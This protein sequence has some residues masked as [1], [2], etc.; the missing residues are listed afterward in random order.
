[1]VERD[2]QLGDLVL[3]NYVGGSRR[4]SRPVLLE[5]AVD[6]GART[7]SRR[8]SAAALDST[9]RSCVNP[10]K[11][12]AAVRVY[13]PGTNEYAAKRNSFRS[14]FRCVWCILDPR[15]EVVLPS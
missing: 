5:R 12:H 15:G 11:H 2:R 1:M 6:E 7:P 8:R 10:P 4:T 3:A 9:K 13:G 14:T